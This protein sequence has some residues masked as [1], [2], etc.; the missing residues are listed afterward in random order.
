MTYTQELHRYPRGVHQLA[1]EAV[2]QHYGRDPREILL[3]AAIDDAVDLLLTHAG[4]GWCFVPGFSGFWR[5]AEA[6]RIQVTCLALDDHWQPVDAPSVFASSGV[7]LLAQPNNPTGNF[8]P[9]SWLRELLDTAPLVCIDETYVEFSEHPSFLG[10][11]DESRTLLV[12]KSF[13]KVFGLAGLR[14]GALFGYGPLVEQLRRHQ[15]FYAVNT[16]GL[17]AL[18]GCIEDTA[19]LDSMIAHVKSRRPQ[20]ANALRGFPNFFRRVVDTSCNFVLAECE[21]PMHAAGLVAALSD[22][23]V[24]VTHC[25]RLGLPAWIRVS[26]GRDTELIAMVHALRRIEGLERPTTQRQ[27]AHDE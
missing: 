27:G 24:H 2:A 26:V 13:S 10:L 8:F 18:L 16:L 11:L 19:F 4:K 5:R 25:A 17:Q 6:L 15:R 23:R 22:L 9:A 7:V 21:S 3:T 20:F 1:V 12:F 14:F